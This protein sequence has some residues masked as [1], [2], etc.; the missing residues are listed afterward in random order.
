MRIA[1]TLIRLGRCLGWSESSLGAHA[2]L[3]VLSWGGSNINRCI[4]MG[5]TVLKTVI[6]GGKLSA[7]CSH[8][9]FYGLADVFQWNE[10]SDHK[11]DDLP[12]KFWR[13]YSPKRQVFSLC[14]SAVWW[15]KG[16]LLI[17]EPRHEKTCLRCVRPG[18]TQTHLRSH[19]R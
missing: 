7:L 8:I 6:W 2:I 15:Q 11:T 17:N 12:P 5:I 18:K 9:A 4:R 14:F 19:R 13:Q 16:K 1:K 10:I 3:L